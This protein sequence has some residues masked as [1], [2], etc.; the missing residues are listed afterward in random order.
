MRELMSALAILGV[1]YLAWKA[2]QPA[3]ETI[4][5]IE[6]KYDKPIGPGLTGA[7]NVAKIETMDN[8][9]GTPMRRRWPIDYNAPMGFYAK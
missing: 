9:G 3:D 4:E 2:I 8:G 7:T 1:G 5:V 6:K